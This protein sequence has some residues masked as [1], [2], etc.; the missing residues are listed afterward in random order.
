VQR[1]HNH[2][3]P[4]VKKTDWTAAEDA[5]I[6]VKVHQLGTRWS[7]IVKH[8]PGRTDNAIKNRWNSMRRK[9]ERK[10]TKGEGDAP[11]S[12]DAPD[13]LP[14]GTPTPAPAGAVDA[15][16]PVTPALPQPG[17]AITT[18]G[19]PSGVVSRPAAPPIVTPVPKRERQ[20]VRATDGVTFPRPAK[21]PKLP[22]ASAVLAAATAATGTTITS[23]AKVAARG[24]VPLSARTGAPLTTNTAVPLPSG[25]DTDAADV[26]IAAYCKA[27]GWPRYRPPRRNGGSGSKEASK[28][29]TASAAASLSALPAPPMAAASPYLPT[30]AHLLV[31]HVTT[32]EAAASASAP[33][34]P[35]APFAAF[36]S[37]TPTAA[38]DEAAGKPTITLDAPSTDVGGFGTNPSPG[39]TKPISPPLLHSSTSRGLA[40]CAGSSLDS[41][42]TAAAAVSASEEAATTESA[43]AEASAA[44]HADR[45]STP[46][47]TPAA[48]TC[49]MSPDLATA[50]STEPMPTTARG[51]V[52]PQAY[53]FDE[54]AASTMATLAGLI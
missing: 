18:S 44:V 8:F 10:R 28:L 16:V 41:C 47:R 2:L 14:S 5:A 11:D 49:A 4:T 29:A 24:P 25:M 23:D 19:L 33:S 1:W 35:F 45:A 39:L 38:A 26:L 7:E 3:S 30:P 12:L 48:G 34:A 27:Q 54:E 36:S 13:A 43:A 32:E 50:P 21:M 9:A 51:R 37:S 15:P 6:V 17:E 40:S 20:A 42:E 22:A 31:A 46:P 52:T 53:T